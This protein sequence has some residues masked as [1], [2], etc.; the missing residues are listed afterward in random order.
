[1]SNLLDKEQ[2]NHIIT[3]ELTSL[4]NLNEE[5]A[6]KIVSESI[7]E[8]YS[9]DYPVLL[10]EDGIFAV[11]TT[12]ENRIKFTKIKYSSK[13]SA[14]IIENISK[15]ANLL[16]LEK[17]KNTLI[18]YLSQTRSY[19]YSSFLYTKKGLDYYILFYDK[20]HTQIVKRIKAIAVANSSKKE[21]FYISPT[22][23]TID[24]ETVI[25]RE[26]KNITNI[27]NIKEFTKHI[28]TEIQEKINKKIWIEVKGVNK[29]KKEVYIYLPNK[30]IKEIVEYIKKRYFEVFDIYVE[31]VK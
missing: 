27:K 12:D 23:Y 11:F 1:M 7:A 25:F 21:R 19:L 18:D 30:T 31:F 26:Y 16:Y 10:E 8:A 3:K 6:N 20:K 5:E 9:S 17:Q 2:I 15:K 13:K 14:E 24:K 28:S 29:S 4:Y 22:S